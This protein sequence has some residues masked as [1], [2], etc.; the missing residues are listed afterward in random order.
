MASPLHL[1]RCD[2]EVGRWKKSELGVVAGIAKQGDQWFTCCIGSPNHCMHQ[3]RSDTG[4]LGVWHH[5]NGPKTNSGHIVDVA[6]G[7][8]VVSNDLTVDLSDPGEGREPTVALTQLV[9]Q[10]CLDWFPLT[11]VKGGSLYGPRRCPVCRALS[12]DDHK[13]Q[14]YNVAQMRS[15]ENSVGWQVLSDEEIVDAR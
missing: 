8:D 11:L 6:A 4:A 15:W 9:Q 7:A 14:P 5:T 10:A 13:Y 2:T 3:R 12:S 1:G